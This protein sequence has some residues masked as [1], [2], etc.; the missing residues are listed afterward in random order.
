[1]QALEP[2]TEITLQYLFHALIDERLGAR[3]HVAVGHDRVEVRGELAGRLCTARLERAQRL[4]I[5]GARGFV[6]DQVEDQ[7]GLSDAERFDLERRAVLRLFAREL[8]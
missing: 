6:A 2:P 7:R 3:D 8:A 1:L 5:R 4:G